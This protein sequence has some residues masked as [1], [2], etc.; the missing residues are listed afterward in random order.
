MGLIIT[1][2]VREL[3]KLFDTGQ[4][5]PPAK[6]IPRLAKYKRGRIIF[7]GRHAE[8]YERA[9][10]LLKDTPH[11]SQ[12]ETLFIAVN[13]MDILLTKPAPDQERANKNASTRSLRKTILRKWFTN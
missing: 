13:L 9:T 11:A 8:I 2:E 1:K 5:Y 12:L 3:T 6:D 4:Q 10:S 7:D